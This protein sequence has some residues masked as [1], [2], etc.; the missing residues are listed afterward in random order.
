MHPVRLSVR[1]S[2]YLSVSLISPPINSIT[3]SRTTVYNNNNNNNNNNK[4]IGDGAFQ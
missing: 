3:E 2:F 1:P 4:V